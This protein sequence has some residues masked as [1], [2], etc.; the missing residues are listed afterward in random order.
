MEER[1]NRRGRAMRGVSSAMGVRCGLYKWNFPL[2]LSRSRSRSLS[3]SSPSHLPFASSSPHPPSLFFSARART[4][5][6]TRRRPGQIRRLEAAAGWRPVPIL[7]L[8]ATYLMYVERL[9][10]PTPPRSVPPPFSL[11]SISSD[12]GALYST[13]A[14]TFATPPLPRRASYAVFT[15]AHAVDARALALARLFS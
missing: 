2:A 1:S 8:T 9:S 11:I 6:R 13:A 12:R 14:S 4:Q 7:A 15:A 5:R 3:L 10:P